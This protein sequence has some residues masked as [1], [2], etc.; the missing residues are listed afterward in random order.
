MLEQLTGVKLLRATLYREV[1]RQ[2][3]TMMGKRQPMDEQMRQGTGAVQLASELRLKKEVQ[4]LPL[5]IGLDPW[6]IRERD[7]EAVGEQGNYANQAKNPSGGTGSMAGHVITSAGA[8]ERR[9]FSNSES[10]TSDDPQVDTQNHPKRFGA[11]RHSIIQQRNQ[12]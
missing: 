10:K 12:D 1:R 4:P 2:G 6:N 9:S 8:N 3:R 11:F 7:R 5:V